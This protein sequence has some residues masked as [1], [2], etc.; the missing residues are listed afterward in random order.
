MR[1]RKP[2]TLP[3]G[4]LGLPLAYKIAVGRPGD[5]SFELEDDVTSGPVVTAAVVTPDGSLRS[6]A[7]PEI[8]GT[9]L[10]LR[11]LLTHGEGLGPNAVGRET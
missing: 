11:G 6:K 1:S 8:D 2:A 9:V 10:V 4:D 7:E 5:L 3:R